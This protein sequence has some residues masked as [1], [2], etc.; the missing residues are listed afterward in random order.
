MN[1]ATEHFLMTF[2]ERLAQVRQRIDDACRLYGRSRSEVALLAV[3]KTHGVNAV[4]A[5]LACG[6]DAFGESYLQDAQPKLNALA[7]VTPRPEWHF[8]G[9]LQSNK[10][11]PIAAQFDWVQ[12]VDRD[13]IARRLSAQRPT[14]RPPLNVCL[15][16]N[17]SGEA[18]KS[19]AAPHRLPDLAR[20]VVT[21]PGLRLR[22]VMAIPAQ[23][24]DPDR[25][26]HAFAAVR[27]Q[28]RRLQGMGFNLD[29]LSMGMSADLEAAIAEGSTLVR[30]GT[31][32]FGPRAGA[33]PHSTPSPSE[34]T[35]SA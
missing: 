9:P 27:Q 24:R 10:T 5:A 8:I 31:D 16:L 28:Y 19:G 6:Q 2:G 14:G 22:G 11:R 13:K 3:S 7:M 1:N 18:G 17:V 15:Q 23:S 30:V 12:S 20:L 26:R 32:L 25:Q 29:T 35:D 33:S 4:R 21:L 34:P